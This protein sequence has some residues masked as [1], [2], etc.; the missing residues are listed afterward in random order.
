MERKALRMGAQSVC[1]C[2]GC[3]SHQ[4]IR[5]GLMKG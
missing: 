1:L 4:E 5:E 2:V 3:D